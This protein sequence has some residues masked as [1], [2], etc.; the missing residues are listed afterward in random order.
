MIGNIIGESASGIYSIA[1]AFGSIPLIMFAALSNAWMP[2]YFLNMNE[3]NYINLDKDVILIVFLLMLGITI[4]SAYI[5]FF[6]QLI[7]SVDYHESIQHAPLIS[8]SMFFA[9]MWNI[10]G[11]GIG[12]A[13][14]TIWTSIIGILSAIANV[15][16]NY[17]WIPKYGLMGAVYATYI[18]YLIMA[19]LGYVFAKYLLGIYTTSIFQLKWTIMAIVVVSFSIFYFRNNALNTLQIILPFV[20]IIFYL[21]NKVEVD[22]LVKKVLGK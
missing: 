22:I 17:I 16:L 21:K 18:S 10:W 2:K 1:Y 19:L 8:L 14:K 6:L 3:R 7:L 12:Y 4:Y 13:K 5:V 15:G 9:I 11:R 20:L